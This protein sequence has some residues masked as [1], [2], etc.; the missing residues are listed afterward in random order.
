MRSRNTE[1]AG[2]GLKIGIGAAVLVLAGAIGLGF[3]GGRVQP[4]TH[5]VEQ[6]VPNDRLPN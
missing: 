5:P 1:S 4:V 3:Y 2:W 6:I